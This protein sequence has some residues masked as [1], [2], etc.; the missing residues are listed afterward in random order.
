MA[1]SQVCRVTF[2]LSLLSSTCANCVFLR[3]W[4]QHYVWAGGH[5][6]LLISALRYILAWAFFKTAS[7]WWYKGSAVLLL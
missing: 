3:M 6:I 1:T 2:E 4:Q 5:F 7:L